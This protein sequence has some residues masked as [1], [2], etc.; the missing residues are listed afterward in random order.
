M[1]GEG[2]KMTRNEV[3]RRRR[4]MHRRIR[5][6]VAIRRAG[7]S[8]AAALAQAALPSTAGAG[9]DPT[10]TAPQAAPV[11][12]AAQVAVAR[13]LGQS[14]R[15]YA[16]VQPPRQAKPSAARRRPMATAPPAPPCP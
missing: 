5:E 11:V 1:W 15:P 3:A 9:A 6:L 14:R 2:L 4:Q 13:P 16:Q 7:I 10:R 8:Y 12:A